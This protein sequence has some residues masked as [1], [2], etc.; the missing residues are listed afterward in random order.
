MIEG[1]VETR[2]VKIDGIPLNPTKSQKVRNHSPDGFC[3]GYAGSGPA[4]LA[5]AIMLEF[6]DKE[7]AQ[8]LY[9][10]FKFDVIAK[11]NKDEDF[12]ILSDEVS[13]W[14]EIQEDKNAKA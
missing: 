1:F 3:W 9:Q 6:V 7:R 13:R 12:I 5:L 10:Q 11:L 8:K 4:Q 14:I 2:V